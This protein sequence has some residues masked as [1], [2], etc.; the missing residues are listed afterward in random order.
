M[1]DVFNTVRRRAFAWGVLPYVAIVVALLVSLAVSFTYR[2]VLPRT[3]VSESAARSEI[4]AELPRGSSQNQI[5]DLLNKKR[6]SPQGPTKVTDPVRVGV[7][8]GTMWISGLIPHAGRMGWG[9]GGLLS[10]DYDL[11]LYFIL[12]ADGGFDR[13][14]LERENCIAP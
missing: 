10:C 11:G 5:I 2:E 14:L 13:L 12:D 3:F 9:R 6:W 7:P 8:D 1:G 4:D